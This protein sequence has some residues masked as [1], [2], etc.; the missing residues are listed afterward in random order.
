MNYALDNTSEPSIA[1]IAA[2]APK[3]MMNASDGTIEGSI[4]PKGLILT[5]E[6]II[7]LHRYEKKGLLLPTS[8][9]DVSAYLTYDQGA[10]PGLGLEIKDFVNTFTIIKSHAKTWDGLR[11]RIKL[12]SSELKILPPALLIPENMHRAHWPL[13]RR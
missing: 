5:K 1:S 9:S 3:T 11:Q 6:Q 12:I 8:A 7:C 10:S 13:S 2:N 4:R